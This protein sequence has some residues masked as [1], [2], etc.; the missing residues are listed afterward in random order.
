MYLLR[1]IVYAYNNLV[2]DSEYAIRTSDSWGTPVVVL[3][4]NISFYNT[5]DDYGG[6]VAFDPASTNNAAADGT[7]PGANPVT[8]SSSDA[9]DYFVSPTNFHIDPAAT[10]AGEIMG[11]GV[12]LSN[13]PDLPFSAD[14]DGDARTT[15]WDLGPDQH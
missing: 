1:G 12:D 11:A 14:I 2:Y 7:A 8:L 5:R 6:D 9:N 3:K 13:D 15:P 10:H 4:N